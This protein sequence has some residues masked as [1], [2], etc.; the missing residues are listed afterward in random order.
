MVLAMSEGGFVGAGCE[1]G[2]VVDVFLRVRRAH[3]IWCGESDGAGAV[4]GDFVEWI[5]SS[6]E[7]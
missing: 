1:R 6:R 2:A 5:C 7:W 4:D 3:L